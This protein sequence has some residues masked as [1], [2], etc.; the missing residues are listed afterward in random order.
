MNKDFEKDLD[1]FAKSFLKVRNLA[2]SKLYLSDLFSKNEI[3]VLTLRF[4]IAKML[5]DGIPYVDIERRTGASS[6]TIARIS[7]SL[8]Y[9]NDGLRQI[10]ERTKR[11]NS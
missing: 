7:E 5:F 2:E 1:S 4:K 8:K 6:A 9:G 11:K 10:L 3:K